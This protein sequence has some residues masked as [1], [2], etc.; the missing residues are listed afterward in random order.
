MNTS[1]T[2]TTQPNTTTTPQMN[3]QPQ[4][5]EIVSK[6][7]H[8]V[9]NDPSVV[10]KM[11]TTTISADDG[12]GAAAPYNVSSPQPLRATRETKSA[13]GGWG[14]WGGNWVNQLASDPVNFFS[15]AAQT[16]TNTTAS[17]T[18]T[19]AESVVT[20][21]SKAIHTAKDIGESLSNNTPKAAATVIGAETTDGGGDKMSSQEELQELISR[22]DKSL[23]SATT[24][25]GNT[26]KTGINTVNTS[27]NS[28][29]STLKESKIT[30]NIN[31]MTKDV[32]NS[33]VIQTSS[34]VVSFGMEKLESFGHNVYDS[35]VHTSE[36]VF[37]NSVQE[38]EYHSDGSGIDPVFLDLGGNTLLI[39]L[40]E[41]SETCS[42]NL[43]PTRHSQVS[44][45]LN[46]SNTT[47]DIILSDSTPQSDRFLKSIEIMNKVSEKLS[48]CFDKDIEEATEILEIFYNVILEMNERLKHGENFFKEILIE[49]KKKL[50][51]EEEEEFMVLGELEK[52][53]M[54]VYNDA[55]NTLAFQLH[56]ACELFLRIGEAI[57][58]KSTG[59]EVTNFDINSVSEIV[60]ELVIGL[61]KEMKYIIFSYQQQI[62]LMRTLVIEQVQASL[63]PSINS[64]IDRKVTKLSEAFLFVVEKIRINNDELIIIIQYVES[65]AI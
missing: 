65:S 17:I 41:I 53:V 43:I 51:E 58:I 35:V 13:G 61:L 30:S 23:E 54:V 6:T 9:S 16:V 5:E 36:S 44:K 39:A 29:Q 34:R 32:M 1:N 21:S 27:I 37:H 20:L 31:N 24:A 46:F 33:N 63:I 57:Y 2:V 42:D 52:E 7:S 56:K 10:M 18:K 50:Q 38:E 4:Q 26:F 60:E 45:K 8:L 3:T 28:I 22:I 25:L 47:K 62:Q 40:H 15:N 64:M 55:I 19:A 59:S 49:K 14:S 48:N 12:G 11:D